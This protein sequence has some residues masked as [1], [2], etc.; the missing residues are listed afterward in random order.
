MERGTVIAAAGEEQ[1]V[2]HLGPNK[3]ILGIGPVMLP[4]SWNAMNH[5]RKVVHR[6]DANFSSLA[7]SGLAYVHC[8]PLVFRLDRDSCTRLAG[9]L[10]QAGRWIALQD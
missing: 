3:M 5:L 10:D 2:L 7:R 6:V 4:L 8:D 1:Q 9:M